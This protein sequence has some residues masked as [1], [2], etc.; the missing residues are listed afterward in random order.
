MN[1]PHVNAGVRR[2]RHGEEGLRSAAVLPL[3]NVDA[4]IT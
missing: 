2:A 3:G 4:V 1:L